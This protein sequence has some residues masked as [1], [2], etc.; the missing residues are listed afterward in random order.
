MAL[1]SR[2]Q[3][4]NF[5]DS[6]ERRAWTPDFIG[7]TFDLGGYPSAIVMDNGTGKTS[8]TDAVLWLLSRD[9]G[10]RKKTAPRI[11]PDSCG[12]YTHLRVE[13]VIPDRGPDL[14]AGMG[15]R[16]RGEHF[17]F[18]VYANREAPK[19][20]APL[21]ATFYWYTGRLEDVP[22]HV[23][24]PAE[25]GDPRKGLLSDEDFLRRLPSGATVKKQVE[26][27]ARMDDFVPW[28][29]LAQ[30]VEYQRRGG[31]DKAASFYNVTPRSR[32]PF[33]QAFFRQ[34][35]APEVLKGVIREDTLDDEA[36]RAASFEMG[37]VDHAS[38]VVRAK[39]HTEDKRQRLDR[40]ELAQ[41]DLG[42][43]ADAAAG[44]VGARQTLEDTRIRHGHNVAIARAILQSGQFP[45]LPLTADHLAQF[46]EREQR[47]LRSV[48]FRD[49]VGIVIEAKLVSHYGI[50]QESLSFDRQPATVL[51]AAL[52][53]D[54]LET[55]LRYCSLDS[56]ERRAQDSVPE[57]G[58]LAA[59]VNDVRTV[60][61]GYSRHPVRRRLEE[62]RRAVGDLEAEKE[63]LT[64][65]HASLQGEQIRLG[66]AFKSFGA[67]EAAFARMVASQCFS[68]AE[69][70]DPAAL[71]PKLEAQRKWAD[72][73][74]TSHYHQLTEL[75]PQRLHYESV[76]GRFDAARLDEE[77]AALQTALEDSSA[78]HAAAK[79]CHRVALE[80]IEDLRRRHS[81]LSEQ[82]DTAEKG[83]AQLAEQARH[84]EAVEHRFGS[85]AVPA[86]IADRLEAELADA[87]AAMRRL[88]DEARQVRNQL[89]HHQRTWDDAGR[90]LQDTNSRRSALA[91][92]AEADHAFRS[93]F[94]EYAP[95]TFEA[96]VEKAI[97]RMR[98]E[99]ARLESDLAN[100]RPLVAALDRF[101]AAQGDVDPAA[102][103]ARAADERE[104]L[105][106][107]AIH[108]EAA[109]GDSEERLAAL[110]EGGAAPTAVDRNAGRL[111]AEQGIVSRHL[112][113]ML[114]E[115][116]LPAPRRRALLS[117]FSALLFAPVVTDVDAAERAAMI[118]A[119]ADL[120]TP[121]FLAAD[122]VTWAQDG[123]F[124]AMV[125]DALHHGVLAGITT[126]KVDIILDPSLIEREKA[127]IEAELAG[128]RQEALAIAARLSDLAAEGPLVTTARSAALAVDRG[129]RQAVHDLDAESRCIAERIAAAQA[130]QTPETAHL[131][132][133]AAEFR[134]KGGGNALADLER[135]ATVL[136]DEIEQ[137]QAAVEATAARLADLETTLLPDASRRQH[138]AIADK[139]WID[140]ARR[141]AAF[142]AAGGRTALQAARTDLERLRAER[143]TLIKDQHTLAEQAET[144]RQRAEAVAE[145]DRRHRSDY[146]LWKDKLGGAIAYVTQ[147]GLTYIQRSAEY[148][149]DL[150]AAKERADARAAFRNDCAGAAAYVRVRGTGMEALRAELEQIR[151]ETGRVE[152]RLAALREEIP[153]ARQTQDAIDNACRAAEDHIRRI[154]ADIKQ[155]RDLDIGQAEGVSVLP[156]NALAIAEA[157]R[158]AVFDEIEHDTVDDAYRSL[159]GL[160][161]DFHLGS[162]RGDL[163]AQSKRVKEATSHYQ[164]T[165]EREIGRGSF[166]PA[167]RDSLLAAHDF[168]ERIAGIM[169]RH[170]AAIAR[171]T[172]TWE[173]ARQREAES[174]A[175]LVGILK[176]L[177]IS[178]ADNLATM[179]RVMR[180]A[181][182]GAGFEIDATIAPEDD[183]ERLLGGIVDKVEHMRK[184]FHEAGASHATESEERDFRESLANSVRNEIYDKLFPGARLKVVHP[185]M[186][187]G[188]SFYFVKEGIS[189]G[190]ATAL[191]L[192]WTIKLASYS[193]ERAAV[194]HKGEAR[195]RRRA[196]AH[197]IIIVDG[198]FSDLSD[199]PLIRESMEAMKAI[200]GNFQL[201]GMIHSPYYR[202]DWELFPTCLMG[203]K[204]TWTDGS[205][206]QGR[207]VTIRSGHREH[208]GTVGI[209]GLRARNL[210]E[211]SPVPSESGMA[212]VP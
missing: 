45:G 110:A 41:R 128:Q 183:I 184:R 141:A 130:L 18:G 25:D 78:R 23:E 11:A 134:R 164:T 154:L 111:L 186:R 123:S 82:T 175:E 54:Q 30:L 144:L 57:Q 44:A 169:E 67:N 185:Q 207:M 159:G 16:V 142:L 93:R 66:E 99:A 72:T 36:A 12:Y 172:A 89:A 153:L 91:A 180:P 150:T 157:I 70:T 61:T 155:V 119:Q 35:A 87:E 92:L 135:Q 7:E 86:D 28:Q 194:R 53:F 114:A 106:R 34:C 212:S 75:E 3:A 83:V 181:N 201:I 81:L 90:R 193:V 209:I 60:V 5:L 198:L 98:Q 62:Q 49:G 13:F 177:A 112:A 162:I 191:M 149:A 148:E 96:T 8:I 210:L 129:S 161:E 9:S 200:R 168:P 143:L 151:V 113:D 156:A 189:G 165:F 101:L 71:A 56:V 39:I 197:S 187:E 52:T 171:E 29:Q 77:L 38:E 88:E 167:L 26:W 42:H 10:L 133:R 178:A 131:A 50:R 118:F 31:G 55:S 147:G 124:P 20:D 102:W 211:N 182:D 188:R 68:D 115:M 179:Q 32:E 163:E 94:P 84:L 64:T 40:L 15:E 103:L 95:D 122:V 176:Q 65:R 79:K 43:I 80:G 196:A 27:R 127:T 117:Q 63:S 126:R 174:R 192:L 137:C 33:D 145:T 37:I 21:D 173:E 158:Q 24:D 116:S 199:P 48:G 14:L 6:S 97:G 2:I 208:A 132:R 104:A 51:P 73:Q 204:V 152:A 105:T 125:D 136:S 205:G 146:E 4:S 202:N 22:V 195:R 160:V 1:I 190:Q 59:L 138:A 58:Q 140:T 170:A 47:I 206:A 85:D 203:R 166:D 108:L 100:H 109:I 76:I 69:L 19:P 120:P 107:R 74:L 121:V 139:H 46:P 17:V